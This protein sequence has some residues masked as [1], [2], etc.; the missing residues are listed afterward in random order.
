MEIKDC[1]VMI[2]KRNLFNQ[3][4]KNYLKTYDNIWKIATG[5]GDDY[6]TGCLLN[7]TY[8]KIYCKLIAI[9]LTK[10]QK[11]D[12]D[13]KERQQ[14]NFIGNLTGTGGARMH[15]IIEEAGETVLEFSKGTVKVL[16]FCFVLIKY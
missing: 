9:H 13:R 6:T 1:N 4:I 8:F 3:P 11:L 16:Q 7:Y 12:T 10:Q 2:D 5:Q 15:F 14:I